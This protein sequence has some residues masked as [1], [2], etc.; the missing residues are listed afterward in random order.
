MKKTLGLILSILVFF[1]LAWCFNFTAYANSSYD[2]SFYQLSDITVLITGYQGDSTEVKIPS[3][4]HGFTVVGISEEAFSGRDDVTK[5]TLPDT[6]I[7][8]RA[9][10]F[11]NTAL[12]KNPKNWKDG[13]LYVSNALIAVKPSQVKSSYKV[14]AG[15]TCIADSAFANCTNLKEI[16]IPKSVKGISSKAF[17]GCKKLEKVQI[18]QNLKYVGE[19]V[20]E[21][22][23]YYKNSK[24][25]KNNAL[26]LNNC[27]VQANNK[28]VK[29]NYKVKKG[30]TYIAENAFKSCKSLTSVTIPDSVT[31]VE[32]G[33]FE[34]CTKL[35]SVTLSKKMTAIELRTF[36]KCKSLKN[37][38]IPKKITDIGDGA[39]ANC[40]SLEEIE[41][42]KDTNIMGAWVFMGCK[43][44]K[45]FTV[46]EKM[47]YINAGLF[48]NCKNLT[49]LIIPKSVV[50]IVNDAF[51]GCSKLTDIDYTGTKAQW[52]KVEI[53]Y[54]PEQSDE[55]FYAAIHCKD[56]IV[57]PS[58]LRPTKIKSLN[59]S[60]KS[61]KLTW[62]KTDYIKG[63]Q[64][65][66]STDSKFKKNVKSVKITKS[67]TTK[68]TISNLKSGKK[69]Y[70]RIRTYKGKERSDWSKVKVVTVK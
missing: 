24:N 34:N 25:W 41:L 10:A 8:I 65:Q 48:E 2:F 18:S 64:I 50:N 13:S 51:L 38:K 36:F 59:S 60:K 29:G 39:F 14:K 33:G 9:G 31:K 67:T 46:P 22:T 32:I 40:E 20:F 61:V 43:N 4:I 6:I 54:N 68:T 26:Y 55:I 70:V 35:K 42:S 49:K 66:I 57:E 45:S 3:K 27:L 15:T 1:S 37:I 16:I 21:G 12:Y 47:I 52:K 62:K 5:V 7:S 69:Y 44:L 17:Y 23:A 53:S 30:T 56:G 19:K 11:K 28:K 63:Y 58:I